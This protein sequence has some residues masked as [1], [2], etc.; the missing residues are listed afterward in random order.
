MGH[1][2]SKINLCPDIKNENLLHED[3]TG[4]VYLKINNKYAHIAKPAAFHLLFPNTP[5]V[6]EAFIRVE[7]LDSSQIIDAPYPNLIHDDI[8]GK[9]YCIEPSS[10]GYILHHIV[11]SS[12]YHKMFP[13]VPLMKRYM[14][15]VAYAGKKYKI[16]EPINEQ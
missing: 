16:G 11:H 10:N 3:S 9:V 6:K 1:H 15:C 2:P 12:M 7:K 5:L 4:K 13:N 8:D 14:I